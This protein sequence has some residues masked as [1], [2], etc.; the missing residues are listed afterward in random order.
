[1][2]IDQLSLDILWNRLIATVN[3]QAATLMRSSFTS[4]VREAGDLSAGVF[5]RR[6]RMV[7][8]AVTG[9]P[10][11]INSMATGVVH[12]LERFPIDT[13]EPGDVLVTND[14]WKT[15]SQ[16][17]DITVVTPVFKAGKLVALFANCCHAL[18][19]GGRGLSADSRSVFEEGLFIPAMKLY[20]KGKP[21]EALFDLLQANVRTPEEVLGDIHS[22]VVGNEAGAS[23]L[24]SFMDEFD[25]DDI[26]ELSDEIIS[27]SEAAMRRRIRYLPDGRY[28]YQLSLDGFEEPLE[29]KAEII[30]TGDE[31]TVDFTGSPGPVPLGVNVCLNYT[32]AYTT[33]GIKCALSPDVPNNDGSFRPVR[34]T[35][36]EGSLLNARYPAAIGGRHLVGHF[37]PSLIMGALA[38][39]L[40][41]RVMA[42]GFDGLWDTHISGTAAKTGKHFSYTWFASGGTGALRHKDGLSATAYPSGIAGVPAE[43]TEALAPLVIRRRE[44]RADSG[45]AGT[46]RGGLGQTFEV[47]VLTDVA[48]FRTTIETMA[49]GPFRGPMVVSMRP[50]TPANATRAIEVTARFPHAHGEPIHLGNPE[51]IGIDDISKPDWGDVVPV[52]ENEV[53]LCWAC[54][55]TPQSVIEQAAPPICITHKPSHML[56]T[57]RLN[58]AFAVIN[59]P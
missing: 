12:F 20:D 16:L 59:E 31:L 26:E 57:D 4:I 55:V 29:L 7:A 51:A 6:G 25:L 58:T 36:P 32:A 37:L 15:A 21:V 45:G 1:M 28:S 49:A 52:A 50:F 34:I 46:Y 39:A 10:G 41:D 9:T 5:D 30:V 54:G 24:L 42:P 47:E 17:N 38:K 18:D 27:R 35:T 22:Q 2:P 53:P 56:I 48:V 40:P 14:P 19:I 11:H 3:E 8:Q 33:Y 23:Q 44:L 13:I 43:V